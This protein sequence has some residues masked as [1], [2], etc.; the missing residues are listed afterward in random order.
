VW[1][2]EL[3]DTIISDLLQWCFSA[4]HRLAPRAA[5]QVDRHLIRPGSW[6][7]ATKVAGY[8][9]PLQPAATGRNYTTKMRSSLVKISVGWWPRPCPQ[10]SRQQKVISEPVFVRWS[11]VQWLNRGQCA[12]RAVSLILVLRARVCVCV[13]VCVWI[14]AWRSEQLQP[15][16]SLHLFQGCFTDQHSTLN[17]IT[18]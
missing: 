6:V 10:V 18:N 5:A 9:T 15:A 17:K 7:S 2:P 13:C 12:K 11:S 3:T 16:W 14:Q 8:V 4:P 1:K